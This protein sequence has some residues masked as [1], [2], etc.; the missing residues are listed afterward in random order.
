MNNTPR[1]F[2]CKGKKITHVL[3]LLDLIKAITPLEIKML[4]KNFVTLKKRIR[5]D[6]GSLSCTFL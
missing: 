1:K 2:F 4:P 6:V 3:Y 5:K